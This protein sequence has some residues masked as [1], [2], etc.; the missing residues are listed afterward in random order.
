MNFLLGIIPSTEM[1]DH[2]RRRKNLR[3]GRES[4]PTTSRFDRPLLYRVTKPDG[5]NS[6]LV[7][8]RAVFEQKLWRSE[9]GVRVRLGRNTVYKMLIPYLLVIS[10]EFTY[11][12]SPSWCC[13]SA[14]ILP[15]GRRNLFKLAKQIS[16]VKFMSEC[17]NT[18]RRKLG[19]LS[20]ILLGLISLNFSHNP[21][22][23]WYATGPRCS[24]SVHKT[25]HVILKKS[26]YLSIDVF[27]AEHCLRTLSRSNW[28]L[29]VLIFEERRNP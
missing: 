13:S 21:V 23:A 11:L 27:S 5:C 1:G 10:R 14:V 12:N 28:N 16:Q 9:Q 2:T 20:S 7:R 8:T 26:L 19:R 25:C 4:N 24:V 29:E 22:Y 6:A 3:P 18:N 17:L 15:T